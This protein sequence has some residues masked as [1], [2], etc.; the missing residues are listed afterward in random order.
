MSILLKPYSDFIIIEPV[1]E[2]RVTKMGLEIPDN[3]D[4][5]KPRVGRVVDIGPNVT[6]CSVDDLVVFSPYTGETLFLQTSAVD[7]KEYKIIR[8]DA[9]IAQ[10]IS[11]S[12]ANNE[13]DA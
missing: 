7:N 1:L 11:R 2:D 8:E 4:K 12:E 6:Y 3:A 13:G 10:Y 9:L 5:S